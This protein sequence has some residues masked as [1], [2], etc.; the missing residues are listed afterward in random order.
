MNHLP[1]S[2]L[3]HYPVLLHI[4]VGSHETIRRRPFRFLS[5]WLEHSD[6]Q[7]VMK[8]SWDQTYDLSVA[9]G[10]VAEVLT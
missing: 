5:A 2:Y 9:L 7:N 8:E 10:R 3:D 1:Y 6:F 4:L